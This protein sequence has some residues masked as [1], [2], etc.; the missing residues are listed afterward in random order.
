MTRK[1]TASQEAAARE[2]LAT[3]LTGIAKEPEFRRVLI[4]KLPDD[5]LMDALV[6]RASNNEHFR[7]RLK[8]KIEDLGEGQRGRRASKRR[9]IANTIAQVMA[10]DPDFT[11]TD[12]L[13]TL[14]Q[15][16]SKRTA[17]RVLSQYRH[18]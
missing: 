7:L 9:E 18:K 16:V 12:I 4:D 13:D 3:L 6:E 2:G 17:E 11:P 15:F 1:S 5:V 10:A 8:A 14:Q